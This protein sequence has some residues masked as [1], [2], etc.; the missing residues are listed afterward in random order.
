MTSGLPRPSRLTWSLLALAVGTAAWAHLDARRDDG[1]HATLVSTRSSAWRVLP[2]LATWASAGATVELWPPHGDPV[3][4]VP[5]A[6]GHAV[7]VGDAVLG[8]VDPEAM[9]GIWD[10]L[11]L[12]TTVR[13]ADADSDAGLGSGGRIVVE[14]PDRPSDGGVRTIVLG[15]PTVDGAGLYGAIEGGAEGTAGLW[16]LEQELSLLVQQAPEAWLARRAVVAET[17][18][19]VA[20]RD[21]SSIL[22]RGI[23]GHWRARL[24]EG[25]HV[26]LDRVAVET[27]IDRL[28]SAR[29]DP[30]V[31]P[32]GGDEGEP[33]I[34]LQ[35]ED[36]VDVT[37]RRHGACPGRAERVLVER[38]PGR[39]GCL[40]EALVRPWP[41]PW[42]T[43]TEDPGALLEP[44]LLPHPYGRV[45]RIEL[46][47]PETRV[48]ARYGGGWRLEE[49]VEGGRTSVLDVDEPEV[50]RWYQALH[51]A[52]VSLPSTDDA[53]PWPEVADVDLRLTTDSTATL[54]LRCTSVEGSMRCRRDDGPVLEVRQA[55]LPPLA[56][57]ADAFAERRLTEGRADEARAL[58]ILPGPAGPEV[59]R[60]SMHFDLGV[61]RLDAPVHPEG[62][63]ALDSMR[64]EAMLAVLSGL[65]AEAWVEGMDDAA[66][67][68]RLRLE[69]VPRR[70]QDAALEVELLS[71][72][73]VRVTGQRPARLSEG[74][75][76]TLRQDLLVEL[77][78]Q[79]AIDLARGLELTRERS[80]VRLQRTGAA[81]VDEQGG[82]ARE[83]N[84]WLRR[85]HEVSASE[86]VAGEPAAPQT[87]EL[88]VLPTE[89]TAF[90]FEGGEGWLRLRGEDWWY[91]L[92]DAGVEGDAVEPT[93]EEPADAG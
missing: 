33:W 15:R 18:E 31:D 81:W 84:A 88:R 13:A 4:L 42:R 47:H 87:W 37:L 59:V 9:E 36:G 26:L 20:V 8:P 34:T 35:G 12:A 2:E 58:E 3:R 69:R 6:G 52:E 25:P 16:V 55:Q 60:Q 23:D 93:D 22:E 19:I 40:D 67:V 10:S 41:M 79:R 28:I 76:E 54:R 85:M 82:P 24:E 11:R 71:D 80:T 21:G 73:V 51:E 50:F 61:W 91:R 65:R 68:R 86:L 46:L 29:L 7:W 89:G 48:L 83:A 70:G 49:P 44:R 63:A 57:D 72:C 66:A 64:L 39:W 92:A 30:W 77:P 14:L 43:D 27:R 1:A 17:S 45:L 90:A 78:L 32:V 5:G 74:T 53:T 62:D 38:G 75:C 56:F